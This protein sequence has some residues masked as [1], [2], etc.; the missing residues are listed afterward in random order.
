MGP[1]ADRSMSRRGM[2]LTTGLVVTGC[3]LGAPATHA[4]GMDARRPMVGTSSRSEVFIGDQFRARL[5]RPRHLS[6]WA[7]DALAQLHWRHWGRRHAYARGKVSTHAYGVYHYSPARLV[8]Y[9]QRTCH[10]RIVYTRL[11]Y[12]AFGRWHRAHF[13]DCRFSA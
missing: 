6:L 12:T 10:G 9:R 1:L 4:S 7:S 13:Y 11:R 8:T 5:Q 3:L 2:V